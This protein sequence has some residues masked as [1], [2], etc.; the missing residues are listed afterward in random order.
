MPGR[1]AYGFQVGEIRGCREH[2]LGAAE[3]LGEDSVERDK[4]APEY[5]TD[6]ALAPAP[7]FRLGVEDCASA[8]AA[9]RPRWCVRDQT[10][11]TGGWCPKTERPVS[12]FCRRAS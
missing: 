1:R 4:P 9:D 3:C 10:G 5:R 8:E 2:D 12:S 7:D 11:D 6:F